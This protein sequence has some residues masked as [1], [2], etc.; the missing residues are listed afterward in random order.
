ML[1]AMSARRSPRESALFA[2]AILA[3]TCA[4]IACTE[5]PA[6]VHVIVTMK[7]ADFNDAHVF[8]HLTFT[9]RVADRRADACFY[10]A[11]AVDR[12]VGLDEPSPN[13]CADLRTQAWTGPPTASSWALEETPRTVNVDALDGEEVEIT[14]TGGLGGRLGTVRGTGKLT[15]T[16]DYPELTVTLAPGEVLFPSGCGARLDASFPADFDAKYQLCDAILDDCPAT[17]FTLLRSPAITCLDDATS[18]VR[19]GPGFTCGGQIGETIVWRTPLLPT[20]YAC[21]RIFVRGQFVRCKDGN[22]LDPHGCKETTACTPKPVSLWSRAKLSDTFYS[23]IPLDCLPPTAV[24][25]TWSVL[26]NL[27]KEAAVIGLSQS[28]DASDD[29]ACFLDVEAIASTAKECIP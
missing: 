12:T 5:P 28:V 3:I 6:G 23:M 14:V 27:P 29:D 11:D 7:D 21:V 17:G 10:P 4:P 13:G 25:I 24:P 8:D 22:P 15:A 20:A 9:A 2:A 16:P 26:L 1:C 19:N 18:R